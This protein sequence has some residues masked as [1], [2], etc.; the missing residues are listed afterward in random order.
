M[1]EPSAMVIAT[2]KRFG[3]MGLLA[4][5]IVAGLAR[6]LLRRSFNVDVPWVR[7]AD[8]GAESILKGGQ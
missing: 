1:D 2:V 6:I 7:P 3:L 8:P 5:A 4:C